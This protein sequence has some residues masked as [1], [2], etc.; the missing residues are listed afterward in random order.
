MDEKH[1]VP[2]L[3]AMNIVK[4]IKNSPPFSYKV[5]PVSCEA[6]AAVWMLPAG[7]NTK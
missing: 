1:V 3:Q 4:D 2:T 7:T 6:V 5:P